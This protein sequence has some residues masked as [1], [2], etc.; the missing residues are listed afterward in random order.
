MDLPDGQ[1]QKHSDAVFWFNELLL[2]SQIITYVALFDLERKTRPALQKS[3]D[4]QLLI[5][6]TSL[7]V[8]LVT[9]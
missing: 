3:L 6:E 1:K 7:K 5:S 4:L 2:P 9:V 8:W